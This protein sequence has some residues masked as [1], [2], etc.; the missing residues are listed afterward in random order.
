M[1]ARW[2]IIAL[3]SGLTFAIVYFALSLPLYFALLRH[4][5][6]RHPGLPWPPQAT[7]FPPAVA[8]IYSI[9]FSLGAALAVGLLALIAS[10]I[11]RQ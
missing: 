10:R 7:S 11:Q 4:Q 9:P 3:A 1:T 8:W 5:P 2:R 6:P